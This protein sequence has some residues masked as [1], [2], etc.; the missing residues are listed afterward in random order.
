MSKRNELDQYY[1]DPILIPEML[2]IIRKVCVPTTRYFLD[3]SAGKGE[4][5]SLLR[6]LYGKNRVFAFDL[7]PKGDHI[8]AENFLEHCLLCAENT[9]TTICFPPF[10]K[11]AS[12]AIKFF[13][14][15]AP[16][17]KFIVTVFPMS[18]K[19]QYVQSK[20]DPH[21]HVIFS[22]NLPQNSFILNEKPYHV[23][24]CF[25]IWERL[26]YKRKTFKVTK[27]HSSPHFKFV[28]KDQN[29]DVAI[30]FTGY[31]AGKIISCAEASKR[32]QKTLFYIK[33]TDD[34]LK[35]D[36][37]I[38]KLD[39]VEVANNTV[40]QNTVTKPEIIYAI[41]LLIIKLTLPQIL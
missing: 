6:G 14:K 19:K 21:F 17:S 25:Q 5:I 35:E 11:K 26:E 22:R 18:V 2:Y 9:V 7:D 1:L 3:T 33:I 8:K 32:S 27:F 24:C 20:L 38:Y 4:L 29:P 28:N 31:R 30:I 16:V 15:C 36:D 34:V 23:N 37:N 12:K 39:M 10:G 41:N 13:N 40:G